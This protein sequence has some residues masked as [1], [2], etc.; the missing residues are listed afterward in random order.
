M[1]REG[2]ICKSIS[3]IGPDAAWVRRSTGSSAPTGG[4]KESRWRHEFSEVRM[5]KTLKY[6]KH[7]WVRF[8]KWVVDRR[9]GDFSAPSVGGALSGRRSRWFM[10]MNSAQDRRL[11]QVPGHTRRRTYRFFLVAL[12]VLPRT[13]LAAAVGFNAPAGSAEDAGA[14]LARRTPGCSPL[15]NSTPAVSNARRI[16]SSLAVV[17][18]VFPS[19]A[20]ARLIVLRPNDASRASCS[21]LHRRRARAAR[22]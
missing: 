19:F 22:I 4:A 5:V 18:D 20:S 10:S 8:A 2:S 6:G 21:T 1:V 9:R 15:V 13:V 7:F 14:A 16:A 11:P 12:A 17:S 3:T